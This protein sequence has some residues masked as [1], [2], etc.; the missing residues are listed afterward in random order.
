MLKKYYYQLFL[1]VLAFIVFYSNDYKIIIAGVAIFLIG[2][3]FMEDGFKLFS[4]GLL[5][6]I[7]HVSTDTLPKAIGTGILATSIMQ[8]SSLVSIIVISFL[9]A[10]LI[11]LSGAIGVIFGSNIGTTATA[12]IVSS[13]GVKI[14]I[15]TYAMPMVIFGAVLKFSESK[16]YQ[17]VGKILLGLGFV[18]LGIAYMKDG[19]EVL[20]KGIDLSKFAVHGY[21][22]ALVYISLGLAAT[23]IMQ[24]SS[25]TMALI[26]TAL[27]TNQ[28]I[29]I[30]ALELAIGANVGTTITAILGSI[31]SNSN[32]K[33]V[34]VAHFIFNITT[35]LIAIVFLYQLSDFTIF[36]ASKIGINDSDYAMKLALFHTI[37]NLIGVIVVS[38]FTHQLVKYLQTL[39]IE[40]NMYAL[41]P[42]YLDNVVIHVPDAAIESIKKETIH[43]YDSAVEAISHSMFLHRHKFIKSA[44]IE[45]AVKNS[46][47]SIN[48]DIN[49]FYTNKIKSLYGDIIHYSTLS[50][51]N[52]NENDKNRV[53]DLKLA[54]RDIVEA[55]KNMRDLQKNIFYYLKSKNAYI[56]EEYNNLRVYIAKTIDAIEKL[57]EHDDDLDIISSLELLRENIKS[58]DSI[59]NSKIDILIREN[60]IDSKMATSLINDSAF[61]YDVSRK[62]IESATIL[63]I[64]DKEIRILGVKNEN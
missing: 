6:K 39:F 5:E 63:W 57:K 16:S 62:L 53:Y 60:K 45:S 36:L 27:A 41:K 55:I 21:F 3:V 15:A 12:W 51:E 38:P 10:E 44:D 31:S 18:F 17:G 58:L 11:T 54:S 35:A 9:S 46:E 28:I 61:A 50:Q 40:V 7:L 52:M 22:G 33:R 20:Q 4:G 13:F 19:F 43:L 34:A 64:K 42:L 32:G 56:K 49:E 37:F 1:I 48:T 25:A 26:I 24:S 8:S 30:N 29:Y 59:K 23:V 14:D 2:M 47:I